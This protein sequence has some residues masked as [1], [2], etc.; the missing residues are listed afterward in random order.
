MNRRDFT[1]TAAAAALA[2]TT[3]A[4]GQGCPADRPMPSN[5]EAWSLV[6]ALEL[7]KALRAVVAEHQAE[8]RADESLFCEDARVL[9]Y[10]VKGIGEVMR[11]ERSAGCLHPA[12]LRR[13]DERFDDLRREVA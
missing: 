7:E 6:L 5:I 9:L 3:A 2:G 4:T 8:H 12:V 1:R 10:L 11:G 13:E